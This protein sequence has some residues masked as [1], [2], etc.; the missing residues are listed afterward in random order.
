MSYKIENLKENIKAHLIQTPKFKTN[1]IAVFMSVPLNKEDVTK[2]ALIPAVLKRGCQSLKTQEAI[3]IELEN[4][5]GANLDAGIEKIGD[6]QI[7]KF[8][9]ETINDRFLPKQENLLE[10]SL[11]LLLDV[12]FNPLIEQEEFNEQYVE[13]EKQT[14]KRLIEGKID[15][16]DSYAFNRCIEEMYKDKAFGLYKY[17]CIEDL[18][19]INAKDLYEYYKELI[20]ECKID[21]FISGDFD[22]DD[23][24]Q[25]MKQNKN[26][27]KLGDREDIHVVN[28]E[29]TEKKEK[30]GR[31]HV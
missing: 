7:I 9:L 14:I 17:G 25:K 2:N 11:N 13:A 19:K 29:Q 24:L 3:S 18:E 16:K 28:N 15:N 23:I 20:N 27:N 8:Y 6:N 26:L 10:K 5:Y 4:M 12:I 22:S 30:I 21:I 1:L 31:A